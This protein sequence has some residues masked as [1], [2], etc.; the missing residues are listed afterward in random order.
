MA[1]T[2]KRVAWRDPATTSIASSSTP[3]PNADTT[4]LYIITALAVGATF[5][6]PTGTP[7]NGQ[8]LVI[9]IQ[10]N[11]TSQTL[12]W[13]AIYSGTAPTQTVAN[14]ITYVVCVYNESTSKWDLISTPAG[15]FDIDINGD[16]EPVT[17]V[18]SDNNY[19]LDVNG[20]IMPRA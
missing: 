17:A 14:Q 7:K 2:W 4:D 13:N 6:A 1:D 5:G 11:G 15:L 18:N 16:L 12:V 20:D 8:K 10:D 9:R 3:T 19:E